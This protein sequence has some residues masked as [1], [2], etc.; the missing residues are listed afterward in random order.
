MEKTRLYKYG[1]G[2]DKCK[3]CHDING[4]LKKDQKEPEASNDAFIDEMQQ[5]AQPSIAEKQARIQS[6]VD[7]TCVEMEKAA[8]EQLQQRCLETEQKLAAAIASDTKVAESH[9]EEN[10]QRLL[11]D[12]E[13]ETHKLRERRLDCANSKMPT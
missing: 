12:M 7:K 10:R 13:K 5:L 3:R 2:P 1:T 11:A 6:F 4:P 9:W 8:A